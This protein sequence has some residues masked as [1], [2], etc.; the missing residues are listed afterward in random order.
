MME[1]VTRSERSV[2][3]KAIFVLAS[4]IVL[5]EQLA[6][7]V[8]DGITDESIRRG[9]VFTQWA[10]KNHYLEQPADDVHWTST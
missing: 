6:L 8:V 10:R 5:D 2:R 4:V 1:G 7:D 9:E 3:A